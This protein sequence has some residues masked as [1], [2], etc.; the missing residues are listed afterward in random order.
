MELEATAVVAIGVVVVATLFATFDWTFKS[1]DDDDGDDFTGSKLEEVV[2]TRLVLNPLKIGNLTLRNRIIRA[3]AYAGSGL[4][5]MKVCHEEV[6]VGGVGMTTIAYCA[7]HHDGRTFGS[8]PV[9]TR[10]SPEQ[11]EGFRAVAAVVHKH[12]AAISMQL[13]HGGGF[14]AAAVIGKQQIGPS[15]TFSPANIWFNKKMTEEDLDKVASDFAQSAKIA[16]EVLDF[17][18]VELHCG[19][20]LGAVTGSEGLLS[21]FV[22]SKKCGNGFHMLRGRTPL[23]DM[24]KAIPGVTEKIALLLF[25]KWLVPTLPFKEQFL[26]TEA[27]AVL[28]AVEKM[29]VALIGGCRTWS[30]MEEALGKGFAAIQTVAEAEEAKKERAGKVGRR[31]SAAAPVAVADVTSKCTNCNACVVATLG[32]GVLMRCP[33]RDLEDVGPGFVR[34]KT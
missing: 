19:M 10:L 16:K 31:S 1:G 32:E 30:A 2:Q 5:E 13:T 20:M 3:A 12:G 4:D 11:K 6:A 33:L 26:R 18:A 21:R 14:A 17:D 23:W 9:I 27:D 28:A 15:A 25:G 22:Y 34:K 8:Q 24:V 29:P 7:I